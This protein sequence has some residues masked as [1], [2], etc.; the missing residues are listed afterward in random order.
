LARTRGARCQREGLELSEETGDPPN[1]QSAR[2]SE[3]HRLAYVSW[4]FTL[5]QLEG[6]LEEAGQDRGAHEV[7]QLRGL[8][9]RLEE[10]F[11]LGED[12]PGTERRN[13]QMRS[14]VDEVVGRLIE[15]GVFDTKGYKTGSGSYYYRRFGDLSGR[16][17]C[18]IGYNE[19]YAARFEESFLWLRGHRKS[20]EDFGPSLA[21]AEH[22]YRSYELE[23]R[24]L[25]PLD[26]P[27]QAAREVVVQS[28]TAQVEGIAE[29]LRRQRTRCAS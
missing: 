21:G 17:T 29:L 4:S 9:Q 18:S 15:R 14:I 3:I 26:V 19:Q 20:A 5:D 28:Q 27:E 11:Q 12:P 6:R 7:W 1:W 8:C 10:P 2:T 25:F 16:M 13:A 23:G 22:P 24:L